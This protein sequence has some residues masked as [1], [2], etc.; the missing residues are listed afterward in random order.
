MTVCQVV[1][2]VWSWILDP[3]HVSQALVAVR[4]SETGEGEV[5][6]GLAHHRR[7]P[8]PLLGATGL[9]LDDLFTRP[10]LR[11][12]GIATMLINTLADM[13]TREGLNV[14]RWTTGQENA[15]AQRLYDSIG[16]KTNRITYDK[17]LEPQ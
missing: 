7:W 11:G 1:D 17:A 3:D 16:Q 12:Q 15:T 4:A 6:G 10:D 5:L 8:Q 13:A 14:V 2:T 9:Y